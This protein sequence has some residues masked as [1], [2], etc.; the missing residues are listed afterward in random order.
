MNPQAQRPDP[1][2][3][4]EAF[5]TSSRSEKAF[6]SLVACLSGLV[7]SSALRRTGNAQLAQ[8]VSQ[9]VFAIMARKAPSLL[10]HP[11][12]EAWTLETTR[13]EAATVMRSEKRQL[14]KL[15]ALAV[16][17]DI[18]TQTPDDPM[19][20]SSSWQDALPLLDDALDSLPMRDR[21][22]ILQRFYDGKKFQEIA[23]TNG[24]SEAA[25]KMR[26]TRAL[27]KLSR[28]MTARGATLT[29]AGVASLLTT[30]FARSATVPSVASLASNALAASSSLPTTTLLINTF[31]TMSTIKSATLTVAAVIALAAIPFARQRMETSKIQEQLARYDSSADQPFSNSPAAGTETRPSRSTSGDH[32]TAAARPAS[33]S[34][35][36]LLDLC[37]SDQ[38]AIEAAR[39]RVALLSDDERADLLE[40]LWR[41]PCTNS[42]RR[43][44]VNFLMHSI[45]GSPPDKM[46]DVLIAEG[47][48]Q[49]YALELERPTD[50]PLTHW[51]GKDP[52][53]ATQWFERKL[54][55]GEF[56]GGLSDG[57]YQTVYLH[58]M[59]GVINAD[60]ARA[61]DLYSRTPADIRNGK[62]GMYWPLQELSEAF[63]KEL[64]DTGKMENIDKLLN[65]TEGEAREVVVSQ[66]SRHF[67]DAGREAEGQAFAE[68]H[69]PKRKESPSITPG[70]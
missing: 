62:S 45:A 2:K 41:F 60:P 3:L 16:E 49:A 1:R 12:L 30:E 32:R 55:N 4:M 47:Q 50:N 11:S 7:Y 59:P 39:D 18:I 56:F 53:A 5:V 68:R 48:Y 15:A 54:A 34:R 36:L 65:Q 19:N 57:Q 35:T 28:L 33:A 58:L 42:T 43:D 61:L 14:R 9:N 10:S 66:V 24:Q 38:N 23:D 52:A 31:Q 25:C 37:S 17:T 27:D 22:V 64:V 21:D 67:A 69:L 63:A 13:L 70:Q 29:A 26:L 44:M 20:P 6:T 8:E 40:D 51:A 46:F